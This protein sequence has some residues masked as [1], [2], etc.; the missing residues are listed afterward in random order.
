MTVTGHP[1]LTRRLRA[2]LADMPLVD[3]HEHLPSEDA[4]LARK[5][6]FSAWTTFLG[7][8]HSELVSAGMPYDALRPSMSPEERWAAI[9]PLW[10]LVR[11]TG[12]G[13]LCRRTLRLF[14]GVD[15]LS[16]EALGT[17]E[18]ALDGLRRPGIYKELMQQYGLLVCVNANFW[19]AYTTDPGSTYFAPLA[20]TSR[21]AMV[22]KRSDLHRLEVAT[23]QSI[24]SLATFLRAVDT[25]LDRL[26]ANGFI[27]LKWHL[28]AYVRDIDYAVA[29]V[30]Q[31]E[32][33]L[34]AIL[35]MP[36]FGGV[37]SDTA[38]G[39]D[40][41]RPFQDYVQHYLVQRAL[42]LD[43]PI[44][45]HTGLQGG[46]YGGQIRQANPTHLVP[47]LLRYPH[48]RVDL[49]HAGYPY[50]REAAAMV[51]LFPNVHVNMTQVDILDP[52]AAR[53][54]VRQWIATL[55]LNK[56]HAFGGDQ[57][58]ILLSCAYAELVRDNLAGVLAAE[59]ASGD[60]N[61]E[62]ALFIA[63]RILVDNA[64]EFYGL[65]ERWQTRQ[66]STEDRR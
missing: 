39:L 65:A 34:A 5:S 20:H 8:A 13:A 19:D 24:Y 43:W 25:F 41:M 1:D 26:V 12:S 66:G 14:C 46:S 4:W 51:K 37:T 31:A 42:D 3:A 63:K 28:L 40:T 52:R 2:A 44:A 60:L 11:H 62:E 38:V 29:D 48:L 17:V 7:L 10:P 53:E 6:D 57:L 36:A 59:T 27:G 32:K 54:Y 64:V 35:G 47:L 56:L 33:A 30:A 9:R 61:E 58:G 21:L 55:P 18:A 16:D 23:G 45:I 15:D 49:L 22:Q 50:L